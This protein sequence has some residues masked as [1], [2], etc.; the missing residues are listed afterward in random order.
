M[1]FAVP[2]HLGGQK[3]FS[4]SKHFKI[5][6]SKGAAQ[7]SE[8][9]EELK[10]SPSKKSL[11]PNTRVLPLRQRQKYRAGTISIERAG[12]SAEAA[13]VC[14]PV[15]VSSHLPAV[16]TGAFLPPTHLSHTPSISA[17]KAAY[18]YLPDDTMLMCT[19]T[20]NIFIF[21][22]AGALGCLF[23]IILR[24]GYWGVIDVAAVLWLPGNTAT[25]GEKK[26]SNGPVVLN[27]HRLPFNVCALTLRQFQHVWECACVKLFCWIENLLCSVYRSKTL[28]NWDN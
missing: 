28:K 19:L 6:V 8:A 11:P 25:R 12:L 3:P 26:K 17:G 27:G 24:A 1:T 20:T 7:P 22:S 16:S 13:I 21:T 18:T 15:S 10:I 2:L 9:G 5:G 4:A 23:Q 14:L